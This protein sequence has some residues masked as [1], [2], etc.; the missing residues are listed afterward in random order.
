MIP[1]STLLKSWARPPARVPMVSIFCD[2]RSCSSLF[3]SSVMS[4]TRMTIPLR[5]S[6]TSGKSE[7]LWYFRSPFWNGSR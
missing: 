2:W 6:A 1:A 4:S 5:P 7:M 3:S